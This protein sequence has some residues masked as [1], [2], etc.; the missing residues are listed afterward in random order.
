MNVSVK[1]HVWVCVCQSVCVW[2]S[3]NLLP[4]LIVSMLSSLTRVDVSFYCDDLTLPNC[5]FFKKQKK[6]IF[7]LFFFVF[8]FSSQSTLI[9]WFCFVWLLTMSW[10]NASKSYTNWTIKEILNSGNWL[11]LHFSIIW[12]SVFKHAAH[13]Q[14]SALFSKPA[15]AACVQIKSAKS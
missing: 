1:A 7:F 11:F 12:L 14:V 9:S 3:L 4:V 6:R 5:P 2:S 10:L 8:Y 15:M 13:A